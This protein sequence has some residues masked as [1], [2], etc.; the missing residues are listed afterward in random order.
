MKE[1]A[2]SFQSRAWTNKTSLL[3]IGELVPKEK[4]PRNLLKLV[5]IS[6][7]ALSLCDVVV[8]PMYVLVMQARKQQQ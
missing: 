6:V 5:S 2:W 1:I 8:E 3:S 7:V 4:C